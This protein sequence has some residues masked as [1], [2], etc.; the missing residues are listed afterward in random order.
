MDAFLTDKSLNA[1]QIEF[2]NLIVNHLTEQGTMSAELLYESPF[3]DVTPTGPEGLF[4]AAQLDVLTAVLRDVELA[5]A[6]S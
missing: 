3:T 6:G 5:A 4:T 1:T 2:I